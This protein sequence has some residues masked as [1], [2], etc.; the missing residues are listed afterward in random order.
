MFCFWFFL[1]NVP[2][3]NCMDI[4]CQWLL[5]SAGIFKLRFFF[6]LC[7]ILLQPFARQRSLLKLT[8]KLD[9]LRLHILRLYS[10][11]LE[12]SVLQRTVFVARKADREDENALCGKMGDENLAFLHFYIPP[13]YCRFWNLI[14]LPIY[15]VCY[16]N[17]IAFA[18]G[19]FCFCV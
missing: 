17:H 3:S 15:C 1:V 14:R 7:G 8:V 6:F 12:E 18:C 4:L 9:N 19:S 13:V 16:L 2:F 11:V 5:G 10:A